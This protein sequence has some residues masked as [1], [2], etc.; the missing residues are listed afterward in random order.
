MALEPLLT[1]Y[2]KHRIK[3]QLNSHYHH[4]DA[5]KRQRE[6]DHRAER[7]VI[8]RIVNLESALRDL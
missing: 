3:S 5:I 1:A 6:H 8:K 7:Y 4:L 2:R